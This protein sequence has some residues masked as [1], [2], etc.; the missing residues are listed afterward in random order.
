MPTIRMLWLPDGSELLCLPLCGNLEVPNAHPCKGVPLYGEWHPTFF[1]ITFKMN[2]EV[3]CPLMSRVEQSS[4]VFRGRKRPS[5]GLSHLG[6]TFYRGPFGEIPENMVKFV[7]ANHFGV[8]TVC[9]SVSLTTKLGSFPRKAHFLSNLEWEP[10]GKE[11]SWASLLFALDRPAR[12]SLVMFCFPGP[13]DLKISPQSPGPN[14]KANMLPNSRLKRY[15]PQI[16]QG[17][18]NG[19]LRLARAA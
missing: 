19:T 3:S 5:F 8:T 6:L 14:P 10:T 1:S 11:L 13:I 7:S 17:D 16:T 2:L 18:L 15:S 9:L 12:L 4:P